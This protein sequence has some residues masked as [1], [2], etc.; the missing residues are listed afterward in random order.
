[1][2]DHDH[3]HCEEVIA[4]LLT[5]LDSEI[6]DRRREQIDRHLQECRGCCSRA[7][8]EMALRNKVTALGEEK[9]GMKLRRR[10]EELIDKF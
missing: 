5:Y 4:H 2:T 7:E 3:I 8:F 6:D 10:I 1:M 9:A